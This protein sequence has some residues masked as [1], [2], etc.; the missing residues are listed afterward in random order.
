M[1]EDRQRADGFLQQMDT[2]KLG[3]LT[4]ICL[5]LSGASSRLTINQYLSGGSGT[6][7]SKEHS[8]GT[9][10]GRYMAPL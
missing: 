3:F 9:A 8:S 1:P 6:V 5:T 2:K 7:L 10:I 4:G